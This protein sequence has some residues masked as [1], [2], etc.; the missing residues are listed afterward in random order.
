MRR[1]LPPLDA[2][3]A[4]SINNSFRPLVS[5]DAHNPIL[6]KV[7]N[8]ERC[9][10]PKQQNEDVT[11]SVELLMSS[12][13]NASSLQSSVHNPSNP[14]RQSFVPLTSTSKDVGTVDGIRKDS[15]EKPC[16][17]QSNDTTGDR[18]S[19]NT[20]FEKYEPL[21]NTDD[22]TVQTLDSKAKSDI[23]RILNDKCKTRCESACSANLCNSSPA[24]NIEVHTIQSIHIL[25]VSW[26]QHA[27]MPLSRDIAKHLVKDRTCHLI[28]F[29]SQE[30]E[31][32][33][34][35]SFFFRS[36]PRW[37]TTVKVAIGPGYNVLN[38][39]SLQGI[40]RYVLRNRKNNKLLC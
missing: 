11:S 4:S 31:N 28:V 1:R 3:F 25:I 12:Q 23:E 35:K 24:A 33:I 16:D 14:F 36:K 37:E 5:S 17:G 7:Q 29:S 39:R 21:S 22:E 40:H 32:T 9:K 2:S 8:D 27:K 30:C 6:R 26:N 18:R 19:N 13:M 10:R 38:S 15:E 20:C 34:A